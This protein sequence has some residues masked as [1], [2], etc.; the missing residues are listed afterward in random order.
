MFSRRVPASLEPNTLARALAAHR[1][2]GV[3]LL[4]LTRSNPTRSGFHYPPDLLA[5]LADARGLIYAPTPF[6]LH[7]TRERVAADFSRRGIAVDVADIVLTASTSEAYSLVFKLLCDAGD[8]VLIPRPS[9]PLFDYLTRLDAVVATPYD[10][11][12]HGRWNVD[13]ASVEAACTDRTRALLIV[14]P[15]NPTGSYVTAPEV[16]AL[17]RFC[18]TR[19]I[20]I[21]SDDVFADYELTAGALASAGRLADAD[22]VLGFTLGGLSKSIGLPQAKL[23]W[24]AIS[25]PEAARHSA[26]QRLELIADTYLS[27][28]TPIQVA[29]GALLESGAPIREAIHARVRS[30]LAHLRDTVNDIPACRLLP[31]EGGWYAVLQVPSFDSEEDLVLSLLRDDSVL[32]HPG[33][34]FDFP[35]ESFVVVSLLGPGD[36]FVEATGRLLRRFADRTETR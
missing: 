17:A 31:A 6:G 34:F 7:E 14:N 26:R 28:S 9:Y 35:H 10:L 19:G 25:G 36:E 5:P 16:N 13:M 8:E 2:S 15:N 22:S 32:V 23:A 27:V 3:P 29:A 21:I 4:D 20:A 12:Y 1:A 11:E 18:A 33:F 24:M 30:N